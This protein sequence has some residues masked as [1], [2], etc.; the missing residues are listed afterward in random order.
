MY[1]IYT[2]IYTYV[3]IYIYIYIYVYIYVYVYIYSFTIKRE[4]RRE[5]SQIISKNGV[6]ERASESD[7]Y[8]WSLLKKLPIMPVNMIYRWQEDKHKRNIQTVHL[9]N[10]L[11]GT[12]KQSGRKN[13]ETTEK[14]NFWD[15]HDLDALQWQ[16]MK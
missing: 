13:F 10:K 7:K 8:A 4:K 14:R 3:Y 16:A 15:Y 11:W 2:Y 6:N 9:K 12:E 1:Y 5:W